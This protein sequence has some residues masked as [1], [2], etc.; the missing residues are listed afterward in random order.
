MHGKRIRTRTAGRPLAQGSLVLRPNMNHSSCRSNCSSAGKRDAEER[1]RKEK[2]SAKAGLIKRKEKKKK[3]GGK[4]EQV[5]CTRLVETALDEATDTQR[6]INRMIA[7]RV[8]ARARVCNVRQ[9]RRQ[10]VRRQSRAIAWREEIAIEKGFR[11]CKTAH[12]RCS[13]RTAGF[14][15]P[16][17][18]AKSD[19]AHLSANFPDN[20]E[21]TQ[22]VPRRQTGNTCALYSQVLPAWLGCEPARTAD[23]RL[24]AI[25]IQRVLNE[26]NESE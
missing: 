19:K 24:H 12:G 4:K 17:V 3:K 6:R 2:I 7:C 18:R 16:I 21:R 8:C 20:N 11:E 22:G 1:R 9:V 15:G 5:L 13:L 10:R 25:K 23:D 26:S 14:R